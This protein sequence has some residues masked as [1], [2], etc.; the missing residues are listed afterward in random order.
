[1][2]RRLP[3]G[4]TSLGEI[5]KRLEAYNSVIVL[6]G[7]SWR[8]S[9]RHQRG[10]K[11]DSMVGVGQDVGQASEEDE[12]GGVRKCEEGLKGA[13]MTESDYA[14]CDGLYVVRL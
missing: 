11:Y 3:R 6:L 9:G 2:G 14:F 5:V 4:L 1:M 12:N 10:G 7:G 8:R 13:W